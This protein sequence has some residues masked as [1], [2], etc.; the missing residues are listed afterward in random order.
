MTTLWVLCESRLARKIARMGGLEPFSLNSYK[1][2]VGHD[3]HAGAIVV[4]VP[5]RPL[6]H[7]REV[8]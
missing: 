7:N 4:G 6:I 5:A 1:A 2:T 3:V 8:S